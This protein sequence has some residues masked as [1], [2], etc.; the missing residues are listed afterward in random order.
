MDKAS[1]LYSRFK[2]A[3][4]V[5]E[6]EEVVS[7]AFLRSLLEEK[8]REEAQRVERQRMEETLQEVEERRRSDGGGEEDEA[9]TEGKEINVNVV[10]KTLNQS[11]ANGYFSIESILVWSLTS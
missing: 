4:L 3:F 9:K 10:R 2:N 5:G 1:M 7:A 8:E 11:G 6:G